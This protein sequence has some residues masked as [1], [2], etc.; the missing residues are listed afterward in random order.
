[1]EILPMCKEDVSG[2]AELD[3]ECFS[4]PWSEKSFFDESEN[5][6]AHYVVAKD[7]NRII[8]YAG[9]WHVADEADITNIAVAKDLRR[10]GIGKKLL[11]EIIKKA[12]ELKL[13]LMTL[14]VRESNCAAIELYK[15]YG[16]EEIGRR[17]RYYHDPVEDALIMTLYFGGIYE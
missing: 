1:M 11:E 12:K 5:K 10:Q 2:L 8:G 15:R 14:E 6:I 3:R 16:F 17:K 4:V 13:S 9:F 7:K